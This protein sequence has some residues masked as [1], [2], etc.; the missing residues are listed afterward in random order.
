MPI[1]ILD[2]HGEIRHRQF[3]EGGYRE[4]ESGIQ[5]L[6]TDAGSRAVPGDVV[7]PNG[8]GAEAQADWHKAKSPENYLGYQRKEHF[9][10]PSGSVSGC[11]TS[12]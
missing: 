7:R 4:L 8:H 6:L 11:G 1:A 5:R 9:S 12:A 2:I 10:S 3:G